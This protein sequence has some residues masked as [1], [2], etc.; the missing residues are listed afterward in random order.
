MDS[1][2]IVCSTDKGLLSTRRQVL[3]KGGFSVL[4]TASPDE[5]LP[6]IQVQSIKALILCHTLTPEQ[7]RRALTALRRYRPTAK[8]IVL[9]MGAGESVPE[10]AHAS[11]STSEGPRAL[12]KAVKQ[13]QQG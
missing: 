11:C 9:T 5:I 6:L 7:Q 2:V 4:A 13:L 3:E 1:P 8:S 10:G 12:I